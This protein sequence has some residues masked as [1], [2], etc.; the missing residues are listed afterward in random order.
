M[1]KFR[2][3]ITLLLATMSVSSFLCISATAKEAMY[4]IDGNIIGYTY[5]E[6]DL[7][8][9]NIGIDLISQI[10]M[11]TAYASVPP[12]Y[13]S[14]LKNLNNNDYVDTFSIPSYGL[15]Y[16][17][18]WTGS[19]NDVG[20]R[21]YNVS[22]MSNLTMTI[23]KINSDG[24]T[25]EV[26]NYQPTAPNSIGFRTFNLTSTGRYYAVLDSKVYS[27]INGTVVITNDPAN[28]GMGN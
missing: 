8:D 27:T 2:K 11:T 3:T 13:N 6:D 9:V 18:L 20:F 28:Y 4:D 21:F 23:Y 22:N 24:S 17:S 16:S 12:S 19:A 1:K 14:T 15:R 10:P 7:D 25:Q 26:A 5:T